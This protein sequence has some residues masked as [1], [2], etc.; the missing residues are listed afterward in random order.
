[1]ILVTGATGTIGGHLLR[2]LRARDQPL[3]AGFH[4]R[5]LETL[6]VEACRLDY[7][8]PDARDRALE[9]VHAVFLV[10]PAMLDGAGML[11]AVRTLARTARARGVE[12]VVKVST[13]GAAEEGFLH[14][15]WHRAAERDLEASGLAWTFLRPNNFV[16]NIIDDWGE[17]IREE[18]VF[19]DSVGDARYAW[20]DARDIARVAAEA[21]IDDGHRSH[22]YTLTGPDALTHDEVAQ[23]LTGVL[24]REIRYVDVDETVLLEELRSSGLS[25]DMADA[26]VDVNRYV[27]RR[28]C[29]V[30]SAV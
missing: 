5:P 3:R 22:A 27:R 30:T 28:P 20:V 14:A 17:S 11:A 15:R 21:L 7:V 19:Y 25:P 12:H 4:A 10:L 16:Q 29:T 1:M 13:D 24:G 9:G 23:T 8:D 6:G 2:E 18:G 26:W